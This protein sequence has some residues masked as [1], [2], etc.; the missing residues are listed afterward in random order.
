MSRKRGKTEGSVFARPDGRWQ[1]RASFG[2]L[3]GRRDR[4]SFYG[5]TRL[6]AVEKM[7]EAIEKHRRG[8]LTKSDRRTLGAFLEQ[9]LEQKRAPGGVR[10][11]TAEQYAQHIRLYL[12][13]QREKVD[14]SMT[15]KPLPALGAFRLD[16]LAPEHIQAFVNAQLKRVSPRTVAL[17]LIILR[18]A[19][20][21]ALKFGL[22]SRNA[23][24]L[25]DLPHVKR[26]PIKPLDPAQTRRLLVT[27]KDDRLEGLYIV[28]LALG[29]RRGACLGMRWRDL[30]LE[31][32]TYSIGG[33]LAIQR[34]G[35]PGAATHSATTGNTAGSSLQLVEQKSVTN[36]APM[37]LPE[38]VVKALKARHATQL[39]ERVAA[40]AAWIDN[41]LVFTTRYGTPI[42]PRRVHR[43]F[44][45]LLVKTALPPTTRFHDMRHGVASMLIAQGEHPR[46]V[47]EW[48][49]HSQISLTMNTY[50]HVMPAAMRDVANKL[51]TLLSTESVH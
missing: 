30:D 43:N 9:W 45:E 20:D 8:E 50:A 25:V 12:A 46:V 16:R 19:L 21:Q 34:I 1:A 35:R 15:Y 11:L 6:E 42:E 23:A 51:D 17:S 36:R 10:P 48:L 39:R 5:R 14:G 26:T 44:K 22:I 33:A 7:A 47:M 28:A 24:K 13:P 31:N 3:N 40:G 27:L 29:I 2:Y 49:G 18:T 37:P 41:D 38:F 32:R 4:R